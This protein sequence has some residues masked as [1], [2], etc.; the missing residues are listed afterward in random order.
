MNRPVTNSY[1]MSICTNKRKNKQNIYDNFI[2]LVSCDPKTMI[3]TMNEVQ[4][5]CST[6]VRSGR[7]EQVFHILLSDVRLRKTIFCATF[8]PGNMCLKKE[9]LFFPQYFLKTWSYIND[10]AI[11][12]G[13]GS[14]SFF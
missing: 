11:S 3:L 1:L 2:I 5:T 13:V 9:K 12:T 10:I 6:S 14:N 4:V 8:D 7:W